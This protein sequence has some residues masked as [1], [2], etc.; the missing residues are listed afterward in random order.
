MDTIPVTLVTG[1]AGPGKALLIDHWLQGRAP[2]ERW[3]LVLNES[4]LPA[5]PALQRLDLRGAC[6]CCAALPVLRARLPALLRDRPRRLVIELGETGDPAAVEALLRAPDWRPW[7]RPPGV[8]AV[9]GAERY[10]PYLDDPAAAPSVRLYASLHLRPAGAVQWQPADG[11]SD[12]V[13]QR[14]R[15]RADRPDALLVSGPDR[16]WIELAD[17][18]RT[19]D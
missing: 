18:E 4:M 19:A 15:S 11:A 6:V 12:E 10:G 13:R 14:I 7:L 16:P 8:V 5:R 2:G 3:A 1:F 17:L 9:I